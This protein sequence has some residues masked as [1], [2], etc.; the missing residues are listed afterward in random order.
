MLKKFNNI[1]IT[2]DMHLGDANFT[3]ENKLSDILKSGNFDCIVF[4]GDTFDPWRGKS[5]QRLVAEYQNFIKFLQSLPAVKVFITGNHDPNLDILKQFG[6]EVR[7]HFKYLSATGERVGVVHGDQF[8]TLVGHFQ[9]ISKKVIYLEEKINRLLKSFGREKP[10]RLLQ[11]IDTMDMLRTMN[12]FYR[13]ILLWGQ[14]VDTLVFGHLH[15]PWEGSAGGVSFY[16]W[17]SWQKDYGLTPRYVTNDASGFK[18]C[19]LD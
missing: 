17:G 4:G 13:K 8:D 15:M 18:L 16:N 3:Y 2:G 9:F 19:E 11:S 7:K 12:N 5:I 14:H 6:F 1:F 10:F